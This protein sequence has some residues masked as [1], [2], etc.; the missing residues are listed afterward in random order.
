[1]LWAQGY[2]VR[3]H[4]H[5]PCTEEQSKFRHPDQTQISYFP[6]TRIRPATM[7]PVRVS[8]QFPVL[9]STMSSLYHGSCL[10]NSVQYEI[11]GEPFTFLVC[12]CNNCKKA[13]GTAFMANAFFKPEQVVVLKGSETIRK[14]H[15]RTTA[16]GAAVIRF[17]CPQCGSNIFL[18]NEDHSGY[19]VVMTG[20][21]DGDIKWVP[22]RE[23]FTDHKRQWVTVHPIP[24][25][26]L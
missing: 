22:R 25:S 18:M 4:G 17:F 8:S 24:R 16:S 23:I 20:T 19:T 6:W 21:V 9:L 1:M 3:V 13:S 5:L 7:S 12:H 14:Y 26:K 10:C 15:D 2:L 11:T